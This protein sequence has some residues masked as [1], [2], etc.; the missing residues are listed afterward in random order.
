MGIF[1]G[2]QT[3]TR[4]S[5]DVCETWIGFECVLVTVGMKDGIWGCDT[6]A[7]ILIASGGMRA[8]RPLLLGHRHGR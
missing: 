6:Y 7:V 1:P 3:E 4:V 5:L 2:G 8:F